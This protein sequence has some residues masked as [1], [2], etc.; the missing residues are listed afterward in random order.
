[1][2]EIKEFE[3]LRPRNPEAFCIKPYDVISA[4]EAELLRRDKG[5][6]INIVLPEGE[7]EKKYEN[8]K[9]AFEESKTHMVHDEPSFYFYEGKDKEFSQRGFIFTVS[10]LD[11]ERGAIK[12]HE[13]TREEPLMDRLRHMESTRAHTGLVW[14]LFES[15]DIIRSI[16]AE[17]MKRNPVMWYFFAL[18]LYML[19]KKGISVDDPRFH[20]TL[21]VVDFET[22][23]ST[24]PPYWQY[25]KL[26]MVTN[27]Q[28]NI[29]YVCQSYN[30]R[31]K[32]IGQD[33]ATYLVDMWNYVYGNKIPDNIYQT[34][35]TKIN[36]TI[37][38]KGDVAQVYKD[39]FNYLIF[40]LP[41]FTEKY[42]SVENF[43][44]QKIEQFIKVINSNVAL[45]QPDVERLW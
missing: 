17:I 1:M 7:G 28:Q 39:Y 20:N 27:L 34:W 2:V 6:E 43:L 4:K 23:G 24:P 21:N 9:K 22:S 11:Y 32:K 26:P 44:N 25:I 16:M 45:T 10:L 12:R 8:A 36:N 3:G 19:E 41:Q 14:T 38:A 33:A 13:E 15:D 30:S 37:N 40:E 35:L 29:S 18:W 31:R 5:N 42:G